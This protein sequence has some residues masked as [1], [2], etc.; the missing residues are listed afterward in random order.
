MPQNLINEKSTLVQVMTWSGP[1]RQQAIALANVDL[2][3]CRH[4]ALLGHNE[5]NAFILHV[6]IAS[7]S[8]HPSITVTDRS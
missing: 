3:L 6:F 5:F 1:L 8:S 4:M 7:H 2:D